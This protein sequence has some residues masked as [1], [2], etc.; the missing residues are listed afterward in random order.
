MF[1]LTVQSE[2]WF[3]EDISLADMLVITRVVQVTMCIFV[4]LRCVLF[5][6]SVQLFVDR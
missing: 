2:R 3:S 4:Y 5:S 1:S 6:L